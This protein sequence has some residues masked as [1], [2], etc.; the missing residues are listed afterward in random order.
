VLDAI[1]LNEITLLG[2]ALALFVFG[3][4]RFADDVVDV[5]V[6]LDDEPSAPRPE[7]LESSN[8]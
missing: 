6:S 8:G 4:L 3:G 5:L 2:G 7:D 1:A